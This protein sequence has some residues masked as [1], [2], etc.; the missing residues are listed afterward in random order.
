LGRSY[1]REMREPR[2]GDIIE[3]AGKEYR[4][5]IVTNFEGVTV[6]GVRL[7]GIRRQFYSMRQLEWDNGRWIVK[8]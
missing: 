7:K 1:I 4:I 8:T 3:D 2:L 6:V 5:D